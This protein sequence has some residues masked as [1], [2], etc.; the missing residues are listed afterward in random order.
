MLICFIH[1]FQAAL[2]RRFP[3]SGYMHVCQMEIFYIPNLF[4]LYFIFQFLNF[5]TFSCKCV[6]L[7]LIFKRNI[8]ILSSNLQQRR[9]RNYL[10]FETKTKLAFVKE[11]KQMCLASYSTFRLVLAILVLNAW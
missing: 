5:G 1:S 11:E 3:Q 8:R 6:D 9:N 7:L 2:N 4:L 10:G